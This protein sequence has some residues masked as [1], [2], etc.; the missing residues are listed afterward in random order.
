MSERWRLYRYCTNP[1]T[2]ALFQGSTTFCGSAL[3]RPHALAL[4]EQWRRNEPRHRV[5]DLPWVY[6]LMKPGSTL[7][8]TR[9]YPYELHRI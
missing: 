4:L 2:G 7:P 8:R 3:D 1:T 5:F 9:E 6:V